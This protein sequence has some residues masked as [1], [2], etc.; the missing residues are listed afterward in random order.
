M[1][2]QEAVNFLLLLFLL[3]R[4]IL[5]TCGTVNYFKRPIERLKARVPARVTRSRGWPSP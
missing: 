3:L 2:G 4:D 5:I 1:I